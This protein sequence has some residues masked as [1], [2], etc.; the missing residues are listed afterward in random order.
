[1]RQQQSQ[2]LRDSRGMRPN[3]EAIRRIGKVT[4]QGAIAKSALSWMRAVAAMTSALNGGPWGANTSDDTRGAIHPIISTGM[5]G[6]SSFP[7]G[8][9]AK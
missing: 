3:K 8:Q 6:S 7:R 1:M 2:S 5:V 4:D 9:D